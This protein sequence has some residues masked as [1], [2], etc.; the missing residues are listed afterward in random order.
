MIHSH[1]KV[2]LDVR[3]PLC[4]LQFIT[5]FPLLLEQEECMAVVDISYNTKGIASSD[6]L[7]ISNHILQT[8]SF[9]SAFFVTQQFNLSCIFTNLIPCNIRD[10]MRYDYFLHISRLTQIRHFW[11]FFHRTPH[12][13]VFPF[14][15]TFWPNRRVGEKN[16]QVLLMRDIP[17]LTMHI[18]EDHHACTLDRYRA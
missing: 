10:C 6:L 15:I 9:G 18:R 17:L 2:I 16:R 4:T 12:S 5:I 3:V 7:A 14:C 13:R 11:G 1:G 8:G